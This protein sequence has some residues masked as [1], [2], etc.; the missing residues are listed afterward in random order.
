MLLTT[1][2]LERYR[3]DGYVV[4]RQC[5]DAPPIAAL[6]RVG[7]AA[8]GA[9]G[10]ETVQHLLGHGLIAHPAPGLPEPEP[11]LT[12]L[13]EWLVTTVITGGASRICGG[14]PLR[15]STLSLLGNAAPAAVADP[16]TGSG[17]RQ[18]WHKDCHWWHSGVRSG[19]ADEL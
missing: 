6:L 2:E 12:A 9:A 8:P 19:S 16:G 15:H 4:M 13:A 3:R 11:E 1:A 14:R 17:Y 5:F 7:A 18:H 10:V